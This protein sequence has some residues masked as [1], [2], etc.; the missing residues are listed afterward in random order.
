M[1]RKALYL[2]TTAVL[3][4]VAITI[5][6]SAC[7]KRGAWSEAELATLQSLSLGSLPPLPEDP[8]NAFG[9]DP[10]AADLGHQLFFDTR[11]SA[12]G[13]VA[14]ASCHMAELNFTDGLR[15]GEGVG[16]GTRKTMTVV[17]TV[18]SPWLFWDGRADS[19]WSQALGPLENPVEHGGSRLQYAHLIAEHYAAEYEAVFGPLPDLTGL[20]STGGPVADP[21]ARGN[22]E[23]IGV[24]AQAAVT[25]V[26][27]NVGKSIAAYER[28]LMP[29]ES[30]FDGY[31]EAVVSGDIEAAKSLLSEDEI[32]GLR[33]FI[34][35]AGCTNC[36][37]G[38]LFTNNEFHNTG[39]PARTDLPEDVGRA[40]GAPQ[41][42]ESEFNCLGAYSD[43]EPRQCM[44]LRFL[45]AE[46]HELERAF[47]PP[48]LRNV[49]EAAPY[50]HAGQFATL[51][52]VLA[53]YNAAPHAPSGHSELEPLGLNDRQLEQLEAFLRS[54]SA[55]LA[56]PEVMLRA[57][58]Q[59]AD[60][61]QADAA[62]EPEASQ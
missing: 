51:G 34:D 61:L 40:L 62:A 45:K 55:P 29:G 18:Y 9:E 37:S 8:S 58:E 5:A 6:L 54:L 36:H 33:L 43:A 53:H 2:G 38:A 28:L 32:A 22:W 57:P 27:V 15:L 10:R 39:V 35:E 42:L 17:G 23:G 4:L 3:A 21:V 14:C 60:V 19:Q 47:K 1:T 12:N 46:G 49:A 44:E 41:V 31:V 59:L 30:R 11:M 50:M 24:D 52:E 25:Q 20:P 48:T 13:Q 16:T 56:A 7:S 26:F